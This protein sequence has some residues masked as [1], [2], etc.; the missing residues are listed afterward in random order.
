LQLEYKSS[1]IWW[2]EYRRTKRIC[3]TNKY[4]DPLND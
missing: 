1:G 3:E 2:Q 4:S